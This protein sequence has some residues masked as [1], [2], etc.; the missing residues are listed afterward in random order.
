MIPRRVPA[1]TGNRPLAPPAGPAILSPDQFTRPTDGPDERPR[2]AARGATGD[3]PAHAAGARNVHGPDPIG[4]GR[5][6]YEIKAEGLKGRLFLVVAGEK[7]GTHRLLLADADGTGRQVFP[8]RG[9]AKD[10]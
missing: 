6:L 10:K 5:Q 8:L 9:A 2:Q 7:T 3:T 4:K 1:A